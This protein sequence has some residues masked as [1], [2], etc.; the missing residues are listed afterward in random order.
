MR[1]RSERRQLRVGGEILSPSCALL[2]WHRT[3][4]S[5]G[6]RKKAGTIALWAFITETWTSENRRG[7]VVTTTAGHMVMMNNGVSGSSG[8]GKVEV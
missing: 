7:V 2:Q 5:I 8:Y 6:N 3:L 1:A 4:V